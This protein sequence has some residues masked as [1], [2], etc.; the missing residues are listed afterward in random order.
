MPLARWRRRAYFRPRYNSKGVEHAVFAELL[1]CWSG[2]S[3]AV[4][5]NTEDELMQHVA[6]HAS[7]AHPDM[8]LTPETIAQ[9]KGLIRTV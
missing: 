8:D 6:A 5:T 2:L 4:T 3:F 1:R 7:A 9:V